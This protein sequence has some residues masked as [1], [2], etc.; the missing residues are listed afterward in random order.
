MDLLG[1]LGD[2]EWG[3]APPG[4][5]GVNVVSGSVPETAGPRKEIVLEVVRLHETQAETLLRYARTMA[6]GFPDASDAIQ[7]TFLRYWIARRNG[8]EIEN[9]K[10]WLFRVLHNLL[11]DW[12]KLAATSAETGLDAAAQVRDTGEDPEAAFRRAELMRRFEALLSVRELECLRLRMGGLRNREIADVLGIHIGTVATMLS[13]I[14]RKT[15]KLGVVSRGA[16]EL[17]P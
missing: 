16:E 17:D 7:E 9:P 6:P 13:R 10:A 1:W 14:L 11:L 5:E 2:R 3:G 12:Y 8:K 15:R 4:A